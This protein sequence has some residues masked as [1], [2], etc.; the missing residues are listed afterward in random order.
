MALLVAL[1]VVFAAAAPALAALPRAAY[2]AR[3]P[4]SA[5]A[6]GGARRG[7]PA[8]QS[9]LAKG[10][11]AVTDETRRYSSSEGEDL[12]PVPFEKL[13]VGQNG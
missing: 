6:R 2:G 11:F 7:G 3:S 4:R 13:R 1:G 10:E 8:S 5:A 9:G 12:V